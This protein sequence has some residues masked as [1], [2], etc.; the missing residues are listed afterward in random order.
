MPESGGCLSIRIESGR[1][2]PD[3]SEIKACDPVENAALFPAREK[4]AS[5]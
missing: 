2:F 5:D 1:A 4:R 3:F